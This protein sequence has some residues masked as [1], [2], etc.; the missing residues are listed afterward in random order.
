MDRPATGE[1]ASPKIGFLL[2]EGGAGG[3]EVG[4]CAGGAEVAERGVAVLSAGFGV[5][6]V[7]VCGVVCAVAP[8]FF[9]WPS[10]DLMRC[11]MA[12]IFF[13]NASLLAGWAP[14]GGVNAA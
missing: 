10:S 3:V 6:S 8:F 5:P 2:S 9:S 11:S 4:F 12:S 7:A 14:V 1:S 13:S